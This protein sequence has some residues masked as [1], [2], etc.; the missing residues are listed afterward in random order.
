[1][2]ILHARLPGL[3]LVS[4]LGL[5]GF[6]LAGLPGLA[7]LQLS[8]LTV[9][10]VLGMLLGNLA[11]DRLPPSC[12]PG[13][14]YAQRT[15]LRAGVVLYGLRISF[16]QIAAIG[17]G[18]LV[19]DVAVVAST[20]ALGL[21]IGP[22]WLGL[23][24][25]TALL[26]ACGSAICGAAAV[27]ATERILQP[28]PGK[29]A[30]AVATVVLF[31]TLNIFLYPLLYPYLG[32]AAA[33]FGIYAGATVHEVAQ[34]VAVGNAID[35]ATADAAVIVKL[36]RVLLLI[37]FL[38]FLGTWQ[39]RRSGRRGAISV[40]W[41]AI[42]FLGVCALNSVI[43]PAPAVRAALLDLDTFLLA[44]AMAALGVETRFG[45]LRALGIRPLVLALSLFGWL[46]IG[47]YWLTRWLA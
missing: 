10:I 34:V 45:R 8:A 23:D 13:I 18:A 43:T 12:T 25:D 2:S 44:T 31:G 15:L 16:Q 21:W 26:T 47:G 40:P 3:I 22:R 29:V 27:L 33:E 11:G 28:E 14:G 1:M 36:T 38:L 17:V 39:S 32:L 41:F 24:R 35:P 4:L 5:G 7:R 9:A 42:G 37:P 20:L 19:L 6:A 46:S 30:I